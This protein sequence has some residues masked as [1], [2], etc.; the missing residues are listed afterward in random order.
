M[1]AKILILGAGLVG[2]PMA[3]DLIKDESFEVTVADISEG[4]LDNI[5]DD[6][7]LKIKADLSN[8]K[9]LKAIVETYDVVLN[10]VPGSIGFRILKWCIEA[11]K[12]VVDIAFYPED[13]FDLSELAAAN[14]VRVICDMGVAPGMSNLLAGYAASRLDHVSKVDIYVGGL[15]KVRT[16]PWEY[17]AVFS[18]TDVIEEYTRPA[19]LVEHKK[20]VTK[21]ALTEIELLEFENVGTLEAFNSDGL[22]SLMFT[23]EADQM[24]E[25]T[26]RYPGYAE[27]IKLLSDNGFFNAETLE[28]NGQK[29]SPLEM[30]SKLLFD[31]WKL[32]KGEVDMTVMRIIVEG[33]KGQKSLRYTFDLYDEYDPET[34]IHSM[35]RTTGYTATMAVRLLAEDIYLKAGITVPEF[36]GK[37]QKVVDFLLEGL[38]ERGVVYSSK[39]EAL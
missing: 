12:D 21:P 14:N 8:E 13:P 5:G 25:K 28:I 27:K 24:R 32:Q 34:G 3:L 15:P 2:K 36:L 11:E 35:A 7:I 18:P 9:S 30:T 29:I 19:R 20:I 16:K 17:K 4:Q 6:R 38:K 22:R 31:Q 33:E 1:D 26:L 39:I 37:D 10:A 23:I